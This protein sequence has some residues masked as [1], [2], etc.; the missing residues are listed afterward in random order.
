[1]DQI[2][3][4]N[5]IAPRTFKQNYVVTRQKKDCI[6]IFQATYSYTNHARMPDDGKL[7]EIKPDLNWLSVAGQHIIPKP[8]VWKYHPLSINLIYT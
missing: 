7:R 1:M 2:A 8:G 4:A 6:C 5:N 3:E